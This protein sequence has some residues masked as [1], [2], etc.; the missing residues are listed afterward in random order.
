MLRDSE[1]RFIAWQE[2]QKQGCR[3]LSQNN[4]SDAER[5]FLLAIAEAK[6]DNSHPAELALSTVKLAETYSGEQRFTEAR[7]AYEQ[8]ADIYRSLWK[9]GNSTGDLYRNESA[10]C[11]F[12]CGQS[13]RTEHNWEQAVNYYRE[14]LSAIDQQSQFGRNLRLNVLDSYSGVLAQENQPEKKRDV[15]KVL[16]QARL[17]LAAVPVKLGHLPDSRK[18][19]QAA[20]EAWHEKRIEDSKELLGWALQEAQQIERQDAASIRALEGIAQAYFQQGMTEQAQ[21]ICEEMWSNFKVLRKDSDAEKFREKAPVGSTMIMLGE[22]Y[23]NVHELPKAQELFNQA[24][25]IT[26][27]LDGPDSTFAAYSCIWLSRTELAAGAWRQAVAHDEKALRIQER[28]FGPTNSK[29]VPVLQQLSS[30]YDQG[31]LLEKQEKVLRRLLPIQGGTKSDNKIDLW[32][33]QLALAQVLE[34]RKKTSE[35]E[36]MYKDALAT[37]EKSPDRTTH[38]LVSILCW[39][40][41]LTQSQ[42]KITESEEIYKKAI[43]LKLPD[44][45]EDF[46]LWGIYYQLGTLYHARGQLSL[47]AS[48]FERAIGAWKAFAGPKLITGSNDQLLVGTMS[49]LASVYRAQHHLA[50]AESVYKQALGVQKKIPSASTAVTIGLLQALSALYTDENKGD[51]AARVNKALSTLKNQPPA[52]HQM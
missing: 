46:Q 18:Y 31:K 34:K 33:T 30:A 11:Y 50:L 49:E 20:E 10:N 14:A 21:R 16:R 44:R 2:Q 24:L 48:A 45:K 19:A 13:C 27:R 25:A 43:A 3:A 23:F 6:R 5:A 42:G 17:Q 40:G 37:L 38:E 51:E 52:A 4:T 12:Q 29:L 1:D 32:R 35:A 47:A 41:S 8:A 15:D 7:Q 39:L 28:E 9:S 22:H 26:E 36:F